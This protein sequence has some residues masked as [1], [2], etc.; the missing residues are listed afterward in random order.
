MPYRIQRFR[1]TVTIPADADSAP[2]ADVPQINGMLRSISVLA[3]ALDGVNYKLYILGQMNEVLY[4]SADLTEGVR[5]VINSL[6]VPVVLVN[7]PIVKIKSLATTNYT[8]ILTFGNNGA[9]AD[10]DTVQIGDQVY[11]F[12]TTL[13][14][15]NDV[16][17]EPDI[18]A[19]A[20]L[21]AN[22]NNTLD[23]AHVTINDKTY[24]FVAALSVGPTV[25]N[26]ILVGSDADDSLE[27]LK[28]AVNGLAGVG[29]KYSTGTTRPTDVI[30]SGVDAGAHSIEMK[31][32][33]AGTGGNS[34]PK[35]EDSANLDWDGSG[36][37]FTSGA[38]SGDDTLANLAD[39][40][41]LEDGNGESG[42]KYDAA[43]VANAYV[44]S[45]AVIAHAITITAVE[46][47]EA[48]DDV[49]TLETSTR[50]SFAHDTLTGGGEGTAKDFVVDLYIER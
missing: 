3:P 14:Q 47:I 1:Q 16:L 43:T 20:I 29:V 17:I 49:A 34:Y 27:N 4:T 23:G 7:E 6:A 44:T 31:A 36:A 26:E 35:S 2:G 21:S 13:A 45:G 19:S 37:F 28:K 18:Q 41:N 42:T 50:L 24:A 10:N 48:G 46:G 39:A 11:R 32:I 5:T 9:V 25:P 33:T 8:G 40:I 30:A 38:W 12:K 22:V 15:A